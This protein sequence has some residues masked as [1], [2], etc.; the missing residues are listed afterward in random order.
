MDWWP[1]MRGVSR[2]IDALATDAPA[3]LKA[4]NAARAAARKQAWGLVGELAPDHCTDAKTPLIV[5]L[6]AT[7]HP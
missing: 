2:I 3:A 4:K 1:P 6:D 7:L 5:D